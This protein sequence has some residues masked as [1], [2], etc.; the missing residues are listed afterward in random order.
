MLRLPAD[1]RLDRMILEGRMVDQL[2]EV[3]SDHLAEFYRNQPPLVLE[4]E[5]YLNRLTHHITDNDRE[6]RDPVHNIDSRQW[7]Q[8][9]GALRYTLVVRRELLTNR[10]LNG[11]IIE[12]HG[13][14]RP[15]HIYLMSTPCVIDCIEFNQEL[16]TVDALD[17]LCFLTMEL[18]RLH[19]PQLARTMVKAYR[20]L[21]ADDFDPRVALFYRCYRACV[22]AKVSLLRLQQEEDH[23]DDALRGQ[24]EDYLQL[25]SHDARSMLDPVL[26]I[27]GGSMGTGKTT[28]ARGLAEEL[29]WPS[30]S[31]DDVRRELFGASHGEPDYGEG[32]YRPDVRNRVYTELLARAEAHLREGESVILDATFGAAEHRDRAE[33]LARKRVPDSFK[34][35]APARRLRRGSESP[36]G[37]D[38]VVPPPR[39][40]P[41][42]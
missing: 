27:V 7:R 9:H 19:A 41:S 35:A 8:I 25:A 40:V 15:E 24:V 12:G 5:M 20:R 38:T 3:L 31:S 39:R 42:W 32:I 2:G 28:L 22:R 37:S 13:D 10:V 36:S 17:D 4:P 26:L 11:R 21:T 14:L 1:W 34:C 33:S 29:C 16:R 6:M 18:D 30:Y 23:P